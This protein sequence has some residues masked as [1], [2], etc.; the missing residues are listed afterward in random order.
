M[1]QLGPDL[2]GRDTAVVPQYNQMIDEIGALADDAARAVTHRLESKLAGLFD[3]FL[4]DLAS[5]AR[6]QA[7]SSRVFALAEAVEKQLL[8]VS[9]LR[10]EARLVEA[11]E[12]QPRAIAEYQS[13]SIALNYRLLRQPRRLK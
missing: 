11:A 10:I 9:N 6:K 12:I 8:A 3:Y 4:R 13:V 7:G 2:F 1:A 5:T